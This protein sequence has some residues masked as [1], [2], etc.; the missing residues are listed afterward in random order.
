[1]VEEADEADEVED[2]VAEAVEDLA[3]MRDLPPRLLVSSDLV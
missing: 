2:L 1:V 3:A